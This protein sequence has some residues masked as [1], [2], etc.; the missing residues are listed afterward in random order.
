MKLD[1]LGIARFRMKDSVD[2]RVG[3]LLWVRREL[4][5]KDSEE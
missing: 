2:T 1:S 3:P 5:W 4:I